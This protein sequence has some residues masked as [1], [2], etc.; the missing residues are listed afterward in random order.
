MA[1]SILRHRG[2]G[3]RPTRSHVNKNIVAWSCI[4]FRIGRDK[5]CIGNDGEFS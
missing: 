1:R 2:P 3:P 4:I 5:I